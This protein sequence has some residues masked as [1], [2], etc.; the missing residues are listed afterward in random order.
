MIASLIIALHLLGFI[1]LQSA[2]T[3]LYVAGALLIIAE[4]GVIS[5][6]LIT[7]NAVIAL[8]AAYALQN[9]GDFIFDVAISWPVLF[10]IAFVEFSILATI[11]LTFLWLKN[12]KPVTGVD[13]MIGAKAVVTEW[14]GTKGSIRYEGEIWK[15]YSE[16]QMDLKPEDTITIELVEKLHIKVTA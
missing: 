11:V 2:V 10:G 6:G 15:A 16:Q 9:G 5:F 4:L 13:S 1:P 8:Y 12:K 7:L 14:S 3:S